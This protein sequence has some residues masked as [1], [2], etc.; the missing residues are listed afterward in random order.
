MPGTGPV[1][2]EPL[3]DLLQDQSGRDDDVSACERTREL[4]HLGG[5]MREVASQREQPDA[6]VDKK[7]HPRDR[8]TL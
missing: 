3:K 1:W 7:A 6:R 5:V 4:A 2:D 8:S